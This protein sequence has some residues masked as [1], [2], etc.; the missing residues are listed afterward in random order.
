MTSSIETREHWDAAYTSKPADQTGWYEATPAVSLE[1]VRNC[2][3]TADTVILD[4]G[5]GASTL[6][7]LLLEDGYRRIIAADI[8]QVA[9]D[10][11]RDRLGPTGSDVTFICDDVTHPSALKEIGEVGV[12]HDRALFHFLIDDAERDAYLGLL[13]SL[14]RPGG[15]AIIA[16]FAPD[17]ADHCSGLPVRRYDE[18]ALVE[19]LGD[20]FELLESRRYIYTQPSGGLR[21]YVYTR[22]RRRA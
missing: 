3:A 20:E 10:A 1:L 6:V 17:G 15:Y 7:P 18:A 11:L 4:I 14:L 2:N 9:L 21:P 8:S 13:R 5:S 16:A 22:F 19:A 12:W